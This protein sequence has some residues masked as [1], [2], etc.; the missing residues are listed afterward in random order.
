MT[1]SVAVHIADSAVAYMAASVAVHMIASVAVHM[2]NIVTV[3][4][5]GIA[6]VRMT[7]S[8]T[9]GSFVGFVAGTVACCLLGSKITMAAR[10]RG[11]HF[12]SRLIVP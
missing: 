11:H 12:K 1:A 9:S 10:C 5:P 8:V 3:Y 7:V 4:A 2:T 6:A